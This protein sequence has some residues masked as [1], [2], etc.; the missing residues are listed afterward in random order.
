MYCHETYGTRDFHVGPSLVVRIWGPPELKM[1]P[2]QRQ[3]GIVAQG[4]QWVSQQHGTS[5]GA[6]R[7]R[8]SFAGCV[9]HGGDVF[10]IDQMIEER[11]DV[12]GAPIAVVDIVGV[13]PNIAAEDRQ[14]AMHQ[15]V[16]AVRRL[17]DG[18]LAVLEGE[19]AP[20]GAELADPGL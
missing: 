3:S 4:P 18:D 1:P 6:A 15:R 10:P 20:A 12:V 17:H 13:L 8:F 14:P 16:L 19:P 5:G 2:R 9:Q 11:L 7:R